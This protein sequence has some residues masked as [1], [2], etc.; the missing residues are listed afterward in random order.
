[1]KTPKSIIGIAKMRELSEDWRQNGDTLALVATMGA[2]HAGHLSLVTAA[3]EQATKVVVSI[4]VNPAQ[5]GPNED[6]AR[7][8][9]TLEADLEMLAPFEVDAVFLPNAGD[10]YPEGFQTYLDN[11]HMSQFLCGASR[12]GHFKGVCTVVLKL[13]N[14]VKP[15]KA[16]FGMKDY[17]QF[18]IVSQMVLDLLIG[19]EIIGVPIVRN[20]DGLALSSRNRLL[21]DRHRQLAGMIPISLNAAYDKWEEGVRSRKILEKTFLESI[22][23]STEFTLDYVKV[24][25]QKNLSS[26][27]DNITEPVVMVV[28]VFLGGVRLIDNIEFEWTGN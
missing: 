28:A 9:R 26:E 8:P 2:L 10:L 4:F 24:C 14:I 6:F 22:S 23:N 27:G 3:K 18:K 12:P 19:V 16:I 25:N 20:D 13:F 11:E 21:D 17:Q 15:N 1:M 7:Y 5:F